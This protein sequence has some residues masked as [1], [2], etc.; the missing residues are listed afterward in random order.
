MPAFGWR[1]VGGMGNRGAEPWGDEW[2][3]DGRRSGLGDLDWGESRSQGRF[4]R[5]VRLARVSWSVVASEPATLV[6]VLAGFVAY[7]AITAGLFVAVFQRWPR[8]TDLRFPHYLVVF[9]ILWVGSIA[10][11]YCNFAVTA[12]AASRLR[13]EQMSAS[14]A[15]ALANRKFGRVVSWT[16][17]AG[18]VGLAL[19]VLADRLKLGGVI[20]RWLIGLSWG[21]AVTFVVPILVLQDLSVPEAIKSSATMFKKRWGETVVADTG[22]ALPVMVALL[23]LGVFAGVMAAIFGPAVGIA[24]GAAV[25]VAAVVVSSA[26]GAVLNVALYDYATT[27]QVPGAFSNYDLGDLYRPKRSRWW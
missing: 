5:G 16:A 25:V 27:G 15:M 2:A 21:L 13:G 11:N 9:P 7:L 14:Q 19:Q 3:E 10:S 1:S 23:P 18:V 26:L 22:V 8:A 24:V 6:L 12:I 4:S 17:V 20:A